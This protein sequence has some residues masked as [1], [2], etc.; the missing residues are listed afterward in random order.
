MDAEKLFELI[1]SGTGKNPT[2]IALVLDAL[3][4]SVIEK[5]RAGQ[6]VDF[7][8]FGSFTFS[9][10]SRIEFTANQDFAKLINY[11]YNNSRPIVID[12]GILPVETSADTLQEPYLIPPTQADLLSEPQVVP[13][14]TDETPVLTNLETD[15]APAFPES[16][17]AGFSEPA[18]SDQEPVF[19]ETSQEPAESHEFIPEEQP[20][21]PTFIESEPEIVLSQ[22]VSADESSPFIGEPEQVI[23]P[24]EPGSEFI[25]F[26]SITQKPQDLEPVPATE[27]FSEPSVSAVA[28]DSVAEPSAEPQPVFS[29]TEPEAPATKAAEGEPLKKAEEGEGGNS[30]QYQYLSHAELNKEMDKWYIWLLIGLG[31]IA[32]GGFIYWFMQGDVKKLKTAQ[33]VQ[34]ASDLKDSIAKQTLVNS[35]LDSIKND[36]IASKESGVPVIPGQ[37]SPGNQQTV[38]V[39]ST[40]SASKVPVTA[41]TETMGAVKGVPATKATVPAMPSKVVTEQPAVKTP[42]VQKTEPKKEAKPAEQAKPSATVGFADGLKGTY[43][44]AKGGFTLNV[45]SMPT[46]EQAQKAVNSWKAKGYASGYKESVVN[47]KTIFRVRVG[48]FP[49]R[50]AAIAGQAAFKAEVKDAWVDKIK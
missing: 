5:T 41:P 8:E 15:F 44:E 2:D 36:S 7:A 34:V 25:G 47:G 1:Q 42:P 26:E 23:L 10:Y 20:V 29:W 27:P 38:V 43:D 40:V 49:T 37:T 19:P 39:P 33:K 50:A 22:V 9:E 46:A 45:A 32:L 4:T 30:Y 13:E 18:P 12:D 35:V 11:R 48:Q 6:P 17:S 21:S 31:V 28:S 16:E 24:E 14:Q 3:I